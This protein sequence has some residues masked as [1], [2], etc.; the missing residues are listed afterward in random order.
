M[1]GFLDIDVLHEPATRTFLD[2]ETDE[3]NGRLCHRITV[4]VFNIIIVEELEIQLQEQS[5][6]ES[7]G[8]T[9]GLICSKCT[10]LIRSPFFYECTEGCP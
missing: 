1:A 6:V 4:T 2:D 10:L 5:A 9:Q 3:A 7:T 8:F